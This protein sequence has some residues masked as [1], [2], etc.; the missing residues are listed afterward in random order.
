MTL[1]KG[2]HNIEF[3]DTCEYDIRLQLTK[4]FYS[5][6]KNGD[7][8]VAKSFNRDTEDFYTFDYMTDEYLH[9]IHNSGHQFSISWDDKEIHSKVCYLCLLELKQDKQDWELEHERIIRE[10]YK[11]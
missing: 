3:T 10:Y 5:H 1:V 8:F 6:L 9:L 11:K 4:V 2:N 7:Q